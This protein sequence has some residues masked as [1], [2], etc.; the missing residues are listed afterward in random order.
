MAEKERMSGEVARE[1]DAS[2]LPTVNPEAQK[3]EPAKPTIPS[4][5]YV[6]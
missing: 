6:V 3:S 1:Q 2:V 5:V 4:A